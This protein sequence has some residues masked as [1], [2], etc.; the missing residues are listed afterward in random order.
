M[1]DF[2]SKFSKSSHKSLFEESIA[3]AF[4]ELEL[5]TETKK[6]LKK[7][8]LNHISADTKEAQLAE[9][10]DKKLHNKEARNS[11]GVLDF[12][13]SIAEA[14]LNLP[15]VLPEVLWRERTRENFEASPVPKIFTVFRQAVAFVMLFVVV[16]GVF[17]TSFIS[18]THIV[19]AQLLVESGVVKIKEADA[20]FFVVV[21]AAATVRLG[22]TIR[23]ESN[24]TAGLTF[25]DASK[26]HLTESTEV[27]ITEFKPDYVSRE[28]GDV[29][30]A[31]LTGSV[32]AEVAKEG[33]SSFGVKTSTGSV[34]A[35]NAKF[36]VAVNPETGSTKIQTSKDV[37]AVK[38][39]HDS[40]SVA[41]IAGEAVVFTDGS[42][43]LISKTASEI[44]EI[45]LIDEIIADT[46]LIKIRSFDALISAQKNETEIARKILMA[47]NDQVKLLAFR[48]GLPEVENNQLSSLE[49]FIRK[50]YLFDPSR[51]IALANLNQ[52]ATVGEVLNYYFVA[53]Q[54]LRGVPELEV[55]AGGDYIPHG[56]LRN[57]FAILKAKQLAHVEIHPRVDELVADVTIELVAN[58][59]GGDVRL[60][61]V[62]RWMD[63]QPIFLPVLEKIEPM[64]P[65][66]NSTIIEAEIQKMREAIRRYVGE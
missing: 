50:N 55:L 33:S 54:F 61:D 15:K 14:F 38:S 12:L 57:L 64:V 45:P 18:Q 21:D 52:T 5:D 32:E 30:V 47:V 1:L 11:A 34:E 20:S 51:E 35:Q 28:K 23:V 65:S 41:L 27:A 17:L 40:E 44:M 8:L 42:E 58:I 59:L 16:G 7:R 6:N 62:L 39:V 31:V 53:P 25:F 46:E 2:L 24:S 60:V 29:T 13:A 37:V 26:M 36:S 66:Q 3:G 19:V 63:G 56:R 48:F 22:D 4:V 43:A 10:L 9:G 49:I